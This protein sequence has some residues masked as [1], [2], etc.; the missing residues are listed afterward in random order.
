MKKKKSHV[1]IKV[2]SETRKKLRWL[3]ATTGKP[4]IVIIDEA[5][6]ILMERHKG[7]NDE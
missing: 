3:F 4:M 6:D 1:T 7:R 5:I 2:W